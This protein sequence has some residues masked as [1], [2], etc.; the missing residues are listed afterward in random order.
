MGKAFWILVFVLGLSLSLSIADPQGR[1]KGSAKGKST[2][3]KKD[4][5]TDEAQDGKAMHAF[6]KE[7]ERIIRNWFSDQS[8][9][10]GLPPGL[11]KRQELPPGLQRQ[12][13]KNGT[14]PP[15]LQKHL[16][17]LP[18]DL[19]GVLPRLPKGVRRGI[20]GADLVLIAESSNTV[21]DIITGIL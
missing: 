10:D 20:I 21:L 11:A 17:P 16:Q 3:Q 7:Q 8:N 18:E 15:G 5:T 4:Q 12:L 9:L 13:H 1:G 6:G 2:E 19:V 14:L